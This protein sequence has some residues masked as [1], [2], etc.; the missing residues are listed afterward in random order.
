MAAMPA[1]EG[2][3]DWQFRA[4]KGE[5]NRVGQALAAGTLSEEQEQCLRDYEAY[6]RTVRTDID[7]RLRAA[8]YAPTSRPKTRTTLGEKIRREGIALT[9][10]QDVVGSRI[11]LPIDKGRLEQ[12][13]TVRRL[14][15]LLADND[16]RVRDRIQDPTHGYRALHL[17]VR[18][19]GVPLEIQVRTHYQHQWAEIFEAVADV[20]GRGI[21][22]GD[23]PDSTRLP[24]GSR[25][26]APRIVS[27][28]Q[29]ISG[30]IAVFEQVHL[31]VEVAGDDVPED[32]ITATV[33]QRDQLDDLLLRFREIAG[34]LGR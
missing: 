33:E 3:D 32:L 21:R 9:R 14:S 10:I 24:T 19:R 26:L 20:L 25:D 16:P 13:A 18:V 6:C 30:S 34:E 8:G 7:D 22:Y 5:V 27:L 4:S 17:I 29:Q 11:I 12:Y 15:A 28:A 1:A 2:R 31:D 23:P